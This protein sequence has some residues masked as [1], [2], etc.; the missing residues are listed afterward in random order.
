MNTLCSF[1]TYL[2]SF[3]V[4]QKALGPTFFQLCTQAKRETRRLVVVY[5]RA[6]AGKGH[7]RRGRVLIIALVTRKKEQIQRRCGV[8]R[9]VGYWSAAFASLRH[10]RRPPPPPPPPSPSPL[11]D[12]VCVSLL[13][14]LLCSRSRA[15]FYRATAQPFSPL[16]LITVPPPRAP[17]PRARSLAH[18][19][20]LSTER[21]HPWRGRCRSRVTSP[22]Q[23]SNSIYTRS[24]ARRAR[25]L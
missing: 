12:R 22:Q 3:R 17:G 15:S 1:F 14:M 7:E 20:T 23:K 19:H 5:W 8:E 9:D 13:C 11:C 16:D 18:T 21:A 10:H 25:Y 24:Q 2:Q 4:L 6:R